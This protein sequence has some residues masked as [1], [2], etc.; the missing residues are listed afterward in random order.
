MGQA[1]LRS[2]NKGTNEV[3]TMCSSPDHISSVAYAHNA[4]DK[5]ESRTGIHKHNHARSDANE[6]KWLARSG[7]RTIIKALI[8]L[9]VNLI[10]VSNVPPR[11]FDGSPREFNEFQR[12]YFRL[13]AKI[14]KE[15]L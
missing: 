4:G 11:M 14:E 5:L 7:S 10:I 2:G 12:R 9:I 1:L 3:E 15:I 13:L 8:T 6:E